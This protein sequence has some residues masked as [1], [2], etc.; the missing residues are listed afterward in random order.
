MITLLKHSQENKIESDHKNGRY[1]DERV[2]NI[3]TQK[4]DDFQP[5]LRKI[6]YKKRAE[7]EKCINTGIRFD[8]KKF[9]YNKSYSRGDKFHDGTKNGCIGCFWYDVLDFRKNL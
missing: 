2:N 5:L 9:G 4:L 3:R 8:A 6:N 1:N 7:C